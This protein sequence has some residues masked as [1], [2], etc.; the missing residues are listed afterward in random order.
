[1]DGA[2][3]S[4]EA[5]SVLAQAASY[6]ADGHATQITV[7]GH[8]DASGELDRNPDLS[9][10]RAQAVADALVAAGVPS[11]PIEVK[12][13]GKTDQ[14]VPTPDGVSEPLNRRVTISI[15]F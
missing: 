15:N 9:K 2:A 14:A 6:A 10:Q 13:K 8:T 4:L 11:A 7:V 5:Q 1:L 3:L 12:W